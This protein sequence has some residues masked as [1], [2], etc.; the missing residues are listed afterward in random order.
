MG[1]V[2]TMKLLF[3]LMFVFSIITVIVV[4]IEIIVILHKRS[5]ETIMEITGNADQ[6]Y[7]KQ[8]MSLTT[9]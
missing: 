4:G 2:I 7:Y 1:E 9:K 5:K 3:D 8:I 6:E